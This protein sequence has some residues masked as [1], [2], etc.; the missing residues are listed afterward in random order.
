MNDRRQGM[1]DWAVPAVL[2]SLSAGLLL[3]IGI[4]FA[5]SAEESAE[6]PAL[7]GDLDIYTACLVDHG[8]DVPRVVAGRGGGFSVIVPGS[9][10]EGDVDRTVLREAVDACAAVTPDVVG[11]L[12]RD[13]SLDWIE[14]IEVH[15]E[16]VERDTRRRA[17]PGPAPWMPPPDELRI[18]C[19]RLNEDGIGVEGLRDDRLRRLCEDL[20]R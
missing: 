19:D 10:V 18:L 1:S 9:L 6:A 13:L 7:I 15:E 4:A 5:V 12:L 17:R 2:V 8:A 14:E 3:V 16:T 20:E 11:S